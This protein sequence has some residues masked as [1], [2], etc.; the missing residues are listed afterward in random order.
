MNE[1]TIITVITLIIALGT[2]IYLV[3]H[4]SERKSSVGLSTLI[5]TG[6][7]LYYYH[8]YIFNPSHGITILILPVATFWLSWRQKNTGKPNLP[9]WGMIA[10]QIA[11]C[12]LYVL[13]VRLQES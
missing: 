6:L 13:M 5:L 9:A 8:I 2:Y 11:F 3:R 12:L 10:V 7:L 1:R 4:F